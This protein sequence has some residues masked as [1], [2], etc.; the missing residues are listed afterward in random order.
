M[1][2]E[3]TTKKDIIKGRKLLRKADRI[4]GEAVSQESDVSD[5]KKAEVLNK[6]SDLSV[7]SSSNWNNWF[8]DIKSAA[9]T[10]TSTTVN[11]MSQALDP[12]TLISSAATITTH[13]G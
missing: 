1:N 5:Q 9:M 11:H 10:A 4:K 13:V 2:P 3:N 6:L 12:K 8:S 7:K